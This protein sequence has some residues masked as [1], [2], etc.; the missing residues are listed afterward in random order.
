MRYKELYET[1]PTAHGIYDPNKDHS[2]PAI[3]D[4][5]K[6]V[7]TLRHLNRLK[8][9]R[10]NRQREHD[11]KMDLVSTM[12]GD[13][14]LQENEAEAHQQAMENLKDEITNQIDAAEITQKQKSHIEDMALAAIERKRKDK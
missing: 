9:I 7:I 4:T 1:S 13:P 3:T 5:R 11:I 6:P 10:K 12:Y 8:H 14:Q 2:K